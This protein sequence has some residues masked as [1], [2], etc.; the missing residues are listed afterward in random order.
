M[1]LL[2]YPVGTPKFLTEISQNLTEIFKSLTEISRFL[3]E[4]LWLTSHGRQRS[5][6]EVAHGEIQAVVLLSDTVEV[7][8][9]AARSPVHRPSPRPSARRPPPRRVISRMLS[10]Y[11]C[12]LFKFYFI[13][14]TFCAGR[15]PTFTR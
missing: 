3:T 4:I 15:L 11:C 12:M 2:L 10:S 8:V 5:L 13:T 1:P 7:A 14:T 6:E 9:P